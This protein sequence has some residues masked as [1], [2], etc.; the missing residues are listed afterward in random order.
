M[1][2]LRDRLNW[3]NLSAMK[4]R[5]WGTAAWHAELSRASDTWAH[6]R[7]MLSIDLLLLLQNFMTALTCHYLLVST[8]PS[9]ASVRYSIPEGLT[10]YMTVCNSGE[11]P[12][13]VLYFLTQLKF[14]RVLC[15]ASSLEA[16]HRYSRSTPA[17]KSRHDASYCHLAS[18]FV[19]TVTHI[20]FLP[21][22]TLHDQ[23]DR[24]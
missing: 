9:G 24:S 8:D 19:L 2:A 7:F 15:F 12:L 4:I 17:C 21:T 18:F 20:Q 23:T 10:E 6:L 3:D 14:Q 11:K 22:I 13:A 1:S 16:T 5:T